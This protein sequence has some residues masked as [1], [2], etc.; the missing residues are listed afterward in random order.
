[1]G[2]LKATAITH[3]QAYNKY[4]PGNFLLET[5]TKRGKPI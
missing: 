3:L 1:M 2:K 5:E 4:M